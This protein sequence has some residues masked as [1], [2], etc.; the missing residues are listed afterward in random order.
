MSYQRAE[1]QHYSD[2]A[3]EQMN[4]ECEWHEGNPKSGCGSCEAEYEAYMENLMDSMREER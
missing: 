3:R 4:A 2:H 1:A